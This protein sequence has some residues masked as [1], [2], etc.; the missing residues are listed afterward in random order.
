MRRTVSVPRSLTR[1]GVLGA[2]LLALLTLGIGSAWAHVTVS[3]DD[4]RPGGFGLVAFRVPNESDTASTVSVRIQIPKDAPLASLRTEPVPGWTVIRTESKLDKPV[5]VEGREISSY[6][7]VVEFRA[8]AGGGIRPGEFQ[9]FRLSG[10]PFPDAG[11]MTFNVVQTYGDGTEAA[12]IEPTV[13]GQPE[14]EHPAPVLTL[15]AAASS[16]S[17]G[18]AAAGSDAQDHG[19]SAGSGAPAGL[20]LVLAVLALLAAV[21]G[22][23]LGWRAYRRTVSS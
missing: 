8:A 16:S 14:P 4:A 5:R 17:G 2:T 20:A 11:S 18:A 12:W 10:G 1:L 23:V 22:C 15:G 3:S 9:E 13:Q 19:A 6:V 7:S 21:S